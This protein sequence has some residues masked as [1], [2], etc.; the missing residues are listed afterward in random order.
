M[1]ES[2]IFISYAWGDKNE[3]GESREEIVNELYDSLTSKGFTVI[4]DKVSLGYGGRISNFMDRIGRGKYVVVVISDKYLKSEFCM[5][6][7]LELVK[8]KNYSDRIFP[9]ILSD[10]NIF[11]EIQRL[12]YLDYWSAKKNN[13]QKRIRDLQE[14]QDA[15][16]A[17]L[18]LKQYDD[19]REIIGE[20]TS[21]VKD[22]NALTPDMHSDNDFRELIQF[23]ENKR[24]KDI[25]F[26]PPLPKVEKEEE[27]IIAAVPEKEIVLTPPSL[28]SQ[29]IENLAQSF[30]SYPDNKKESSSS[31]LPI[32]RIAAVIVFLLI[33]VFGIIKMTGDNSAN[34]KKILTG[35][36]GEPK[37]NVPPQLNSKGGTAAI[38]T[39]ELA[40]KWKLTFVFEKCKGSTDDRFVQGGLETYYEFNIEQ[41]GKIINGRGKKY[42]ETYNGKSK[43]YR[44]GTHN[45][46]INGKIINGR[47]EA[48]FSVLST[49]NI[50]TKNTINI[51]LSNHFIFEGSF[52]TSAR[53]CMGAAKLQKIN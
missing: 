41:T 26:V 1:N 22:V 34:G 31:K 13:L 8:N 28:S 35:G 49:N 10:A 25:S 6:E 9:I 33:G 50:E 36:D 39:K 48:K 29:P 17:H 12:E 38:K 27:K 51:D 4:R 52:T 30:A 21:F 45:A 47:L 43:D 42:G 14:L 32:G 23:L 44:E 7:I 5:Y 20:F 16:A 19:I 18:K 37:V 46:A 24:L 53:K 15:T 3:K 40:G 11:D 2:E